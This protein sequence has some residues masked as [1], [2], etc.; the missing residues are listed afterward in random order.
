MQK[1]RSS[2]ENKI[3]IYKASAGSGKTHKITEQY[4]LLLLDKYTPYVYKNILA[5]TFTNKATDEMKSRII[6]E[7]AVL[8]S[9]RESSY[10]DKLTEYYNI[11][12]EDLRVRAKDVL[13]R[14]L[15]DYSLF[16]VST[17]DK[18]FQQTMRAF[19]RELGID[20][21]YGIELDTD[22][23]LLEA[24]DNLLSN[25]EENRN[26]LLLDWLIRF[27]AE[28][29]EEGSSW[30]IKQDIHKLGKEIFKED[31]KANR[32]NIQAD[33]N[34][35]ALLEEY[36]KDLL[37][38]IF[39]YENHLQT[40]GREALEIIAEKGLQTSDFKGGQRSIFGF[41]LKLAN[42]EDFEPKDSFY[43]LRND[44]DSWYTKTTSQEVKAKISNVYPALNRKI[45]E[46][47]DFIASGSVDYVTAKEVNR[48]FF[49][50]GILGDIDAE[51]RNYA[52][53]NNILLISDTTELLNRIIGGSDAPFIYEKV[54]QYIDHYMI[55]EFQDTSGMQWENF[56]PLLKDSLAHGNKD[57]VVGDVKQ[58]IYRWRSSDWNLLN[59]QI[60]EDF[61]PKQ[62]EH[63]TLFTNWRSFK[64]VVLFNN[65]I[66][67]KSSKILQN[68]FNQPEF[69]NQKFFAKYLTKIT[70]VYS[71]VVQEVPDSKADTE[72]YVKIQFI[73]TTDNKDWKQ[74]A[75]ERLPKEIEALQDSGL[76]L[77]DIAILVRTKKEGIEIANYL[78][79]YKEQNQNSKYRYDIISDEALYL[80]NSQSIKLILALLKYLHSPEDDSL[81]SLAI[82]EYIKF[83]DQI[84]DQE[85]LMKY[86]SSDREFTPEMIERFDSI[87]KLSLYEM[88]ESI[89]GFFIH[90]I[91]QKEYVYIQS[92]MD[93]ALDYTNKYSADLSMFLNWWKETGIK[94]TIF[95]PDSQNAIK[96]LTVHKS[97]GLGFDAVL[98]PFC[99]WSIDHSN[100]MADVI[101]W[102]KPQV[103]PFSKLHILPVKYSKRLEKSYF[104]EEYF[105]EKLHTYIDNLNILYVAFT[106]AK[107]CLIAFAP[108]SQKSEIANIGSLLYETIMHRNLPVE[109]NCI[110]LD[111]QMN[112]EE[113]TMEIGSYEALTKKKDQKLKGELA[114]NYF[115]SISFD[116]RLKLK[117]NNKNFFD[118]RGRRDY[119]NLLH[120]ILSKIVVATDLPR[121][122]MRFVSLGAITLSES[123]EIN[124]LLSS[125]I[126]KKNVSKWF[127]GYYSV[128]NETQI[129]TP[130]KPMIRPDRIMTKGDT[131]IVID[132]KFGILEN[133][134]YNKQ[135]KYY[136]SQIQNLG[137]S[138][139][140]G[141]IC[142]V[143]LDKIVKI[144]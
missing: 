85:A 82:C 57:F 23:V 39:T 103:E 131:A 84:S 42:K 74:T 14:I 58:S 20:G 119:G 53:S 59:S 56:R 4:L 49:V 114:L 16:T 107:K 31:F 12:E 30:N 63:E 10:V 118:E 78:L 33:I 126:N 36:K 44:I 9:D 29:V 117:L 69:I 17:I 52:T 73:D 2:E 96:I 76:E 27:T 72:G 93:F 38:I 13:V 128:M 41:F 130:N 1:Q 50:L 75:L 26:G 67:N 7:L 88:I 47:L 21:N 106:R 18:F 140:K 28:K 111:K 91:D 99:N 43:G 102:C 110:V 113:L 116:H 45:C 61:D 22:K 123:E 54:G 6:E 112:M 108:Y 94:K 68:V 133:Q 37:K 101:L 86:F 11:S 120:D 15:H 124:T 138:D 137:F 141:Y 125:F 134:K 89:V 129:F 98:I 8:A 34:N 66:F 100:P 143:S 80:S 121:V 51:V 115:P 64:N 77:K 48:Y 60:D 5:V 92:F 136:M 83:K 62:I 35:K 46:I 104:F 79:D 3:I 144:I 81:K 132:Y 87:R 55:D 24:I 19:T 70:D 32:D 25:L 90:T 135:I 109:E 105:K 65:T 95:T 71:D 97:K 139:I 122:L 127:S 142:Y 40:L